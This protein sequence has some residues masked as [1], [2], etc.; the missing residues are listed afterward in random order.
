MSRLKGLDSAVERF[1]SVCRNLCG[2]VDGSCDRIYGL[3]DGLPAML[4][5]F[6]RDLFGLSL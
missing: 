6:R 3:V 1:G 5:G 4:D 2:A